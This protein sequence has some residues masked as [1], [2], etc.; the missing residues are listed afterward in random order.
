MADFL[1]I[2]L[3]GENCQAMVT[4]GSVPPGHLGQL[5][6]DLQPGHSGPLHYDK[7]DS[8]WWSA[9]RIDRAPSKDGS[10]G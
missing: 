4:V 6:C 1:K 5:V 2:V 10:N 7:V 3:R 8:I 9:D